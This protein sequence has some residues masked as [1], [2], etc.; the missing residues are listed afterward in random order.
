RGGP[1]S[2]LLCDCLRQKAYQMAVLAG[3][4]RYSPPVAGFSVLFAAGGRFG[5]YG[6]QFAAT[7]F[8]GVV[9]S[10]KSGAGPAGR[11]PTKRSF[12]HCFL[13]FYANRDEKSG[14]RKES[15]GHAAALVL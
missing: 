8:V 9:C 11:D 14:G 7:G 2:W 15:R 5:G 10:T 3:R 12:Q 13:L 4:N 6:V 1:V